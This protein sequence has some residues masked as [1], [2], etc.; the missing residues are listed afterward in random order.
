MSQVPSSVWTRSTK[1]N[2]RPSASRNPRP[3][4]STTITVMPGLVISQKSASRAE[5][6]RDGSSS[7][8]VFESASMKTRGGLP[9][10]RRAGGSL[11]RTEGGLHL[12]HPPPAVQPQPISGGDRPVDSRTV[13]DG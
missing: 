13:D 1:A 3:A 11:A 7:L 9:Q 5:T 8:S 6:G 2:D 4:V 12:H 10:G